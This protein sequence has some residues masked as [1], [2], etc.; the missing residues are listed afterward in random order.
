MILGAFVAIIVMFI[1]FKSLSLQVLDQLPIISAYIYKNP[2]HKVNAKIIRVE[3]RL[4]EKRFNPNIKY[5]Q[6]E[7]REFLPSNFKKYYISNSQE[8]NAA[9]TN[10]NSKKSSE[11]ILILKDGIYEILSTIMITRPNTFIIS[12]SGDPSK[13]V[14][15]GN[16]MLKSSGVMNIFTVQA[17]GFLLDGVT[18]KE[19]SNHL[20]QIK[21]EMGANFP[22]IRNCIL[23]DSYQ[24]LI[25]V[26]TGTK[27]R[28]SESGLIENC[29]FE[30]TAGIGPNYYIGGIDAHGVRN[31]LI[32]NNIF[33]SIASP[34]Q[35]IS[36]YA[37]HLWGNAQNNLVDSNIIINSD[38]GIG[39]GMGNNK[40]AKF[41]NFAGVISN[42][43]IF[44]SNNGHQ[45]ADTGIALESSPK[46][47]IEGNYIYLAHDYHR[48]IEYR[49][50]DSQQITV[51]NNHVNRSIS[52]RNGGQAELSNNNNLD[53]VDFL[54]KMKEVLSLSNIARAMDNDR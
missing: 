9:I 18:L 31:W 32:R 52:S 12:F 39:F 14:L 45:F 26:T 5:L 48:A 41:S 24:Q 1:P 4:S 6:R 49:F 30:Y 36:E 23:Q 40:G 7:I 53:M 8:L 33:K 28:A 17:A 10:I 54:I 2:K 42:N 37:I 35:Q 47:L 51:R 44:H 50:A 27:N 19:V 34:Q 29:L 43:I 46:T 22:I 25:K 38:R 11:N 15:K 21:G 13:V 16:G 3:A 20:I